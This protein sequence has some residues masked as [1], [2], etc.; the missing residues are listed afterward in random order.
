MI[1][2][3]FD[4]FFFFF[5]FFFFFSLEIMREE[6]KLM[7]ENLFFREAG[8]L[9]AVLREKAVLREAVLK[10]AVLRKA[11]LREAVLRVTREE[12][13]KE[14]RDDLLEI[15]EFCRFRLFRSF[16]FQKVTKMKMRR[17][18]AEQRGMT[19]YISTNEVFTDRT[20]DEI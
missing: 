6:N 20:D 8:V 2:L 13:R 12:K 16:I 19:D 14:R 17:R 1:L 18:A 11:V 10:E 9:R 3:S 15:I 7:F 4:S 5:F